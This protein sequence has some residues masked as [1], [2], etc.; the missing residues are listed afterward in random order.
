MKNF[1]RWLYQR[2][3]EGYETSPAV[4]IQHPIKMWMVQPDRY[5][6]Y[7]ARKGRQIGLAVDD[8]WCGGGPVDVA[9]KVTYFDIGRGRVDIGL[10]TRKGEERKQIRLTGSGKLKTAT[11]FI[12]DALFSAGNMDYDIIFKSSGTEAVLSFVRVIRL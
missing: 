12:D 10:R 7:I 5:F 6:D 3:S 9:L 2:D 8:R 11:F 1:E 4:K